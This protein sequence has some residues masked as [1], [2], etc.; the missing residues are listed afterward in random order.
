MLSGMSVSKVCTLDQAP[1]LLLSLSSHHVAPAR[2]RDAF[3]YDS[4]PFSRAE[5]LT[6]N[7]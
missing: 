7:L 6:W 3:P 4:G 2:S 1:S 5:E